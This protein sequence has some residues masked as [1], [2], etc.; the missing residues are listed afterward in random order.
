ML[1]FMCLS[2]RNVNRQSYVHC[3]AHPLDLVLVDVVK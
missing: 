2:K 1:A 3:C